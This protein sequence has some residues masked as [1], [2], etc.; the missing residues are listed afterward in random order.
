[1]VSK[2]WSVMGFLLE[3][4]WHVCF[5]FPGKVCHT[6]GRKKGQPIYDLKPCSTGHI[7]AS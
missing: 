2:L 7:S 5:I 6:T 1:M 3:M 4:N